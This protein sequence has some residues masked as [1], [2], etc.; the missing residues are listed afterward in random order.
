M[1]TGALNKSDAEKLRTSDV[2]HLTKTVRELTFVL[3][4]N[5]FLSSSDRKH[6]DSMLI[7]R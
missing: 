3:E 7:L 4:K 6:I 2:A 1:E 5:G